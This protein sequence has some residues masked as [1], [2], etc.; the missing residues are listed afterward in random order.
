[1]TQPG[2]WHLLSWQ[3]GPLSLSSPR[4]FGF[5]PL[6]PPLPQVS[7][8][9][10]FWS[11]VFHTRDTAVTEVSGALRTSV[12][13][14]SSPSVPKP[15][16]GSCCSAP[17]GAGGAVCWSPCPSSSCQ[18]GSPSPNPAETGLFLRFGRHPALRVPVL[19]QVSPVSTVGHQAVGQGAGDTDGG[20]FPAPSATLSSSSS[21]SPLSPGRWG[22]SGQP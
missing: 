10:W 4:H 11:T 1:M 19:R 18:H 9:A 17:L 20:R 21:S 15:V 22:C 16:L 3:R 13:V 12:S 5:P 8:N 6:T 2:S 7:L 14:G